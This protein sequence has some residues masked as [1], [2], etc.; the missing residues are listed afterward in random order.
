MIYTAKFW[1]KTKERNAWNEPITPYKLYKAADD[2][3]RLILRHLQGG[4]RFPDFV[5]EAH[6]P[7]VKKMLYVHG[8]K[9]IQ[10]EDWPNENR[11]A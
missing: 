6:F 1:V 11:E 2:D 4:K 10:L 3:T 8:V 5:V 9:T 7:E